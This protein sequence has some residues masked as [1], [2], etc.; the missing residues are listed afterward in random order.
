MVYTVV[1]CSPFGRTSKQISNATVFTRV[2]F[3]LGSEAQIVPNC[4]R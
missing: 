4:H 2:P 3:F 1:A